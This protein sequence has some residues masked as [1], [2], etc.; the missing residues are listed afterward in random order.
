LAER[1]A[2]HARRVREPVAIDRGVQPWSQC[3]QPPATMRYR[4]FEY[5]YAAV[6]RT[7]QVWLQTDPWPSDRLRLL[8]HGRWSPDADLYA[9]AATVEIVVDLA[10]VSEEDFEI[11]R[12]DDALI[13]EGRGRRAGRHT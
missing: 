4:R 7:G 1:C 10:G 9:T 13:I 6:I 11:G 12:F 8:V 3:R 5:R 2:P